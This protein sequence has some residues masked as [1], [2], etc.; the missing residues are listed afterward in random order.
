MVSGIAIVIGL[1]TALSVRALHPRLRTPLLVAI[2]AGLIGGWLGSMALAPLW[3]P[4]LGDMHAAAQVAGGACGG[5]LAAVAAV[6][7]HHVRLSQ[8]A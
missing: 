7:G 8:S 4:V 6:V 5:I 3:Q 2:P 1:M